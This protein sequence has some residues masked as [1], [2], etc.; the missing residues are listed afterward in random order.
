MNRKEKATIKKSIFIL[1]CF[2][3]LTACSHP[4]NDNI[5]SAQSSSPPAVSTP[6]AES[7]P[8]P[9]SPPP[10]ETSPPG[11]PAA[12]TPN[13]AA[14]EI[15]TPNVSQREL[16]D[17]EALRFTAD[18]KAGW[19]LGN[20]FDSTG[21][22]V[23]KGLGETAWGNPKTTREM[24]QKIHE[25]GF[26]SIRIPV[27]WHDH[28]DADFNIDAAWMERVA[29]VAGYALD[30]NMYVILNIH[31]D[32]GVKYVYPDSEHY[33]NSSKYIKTVWKQIAEQ[34]KDKSEKLI[35]ESINEPRLIGTEH[36]WDMQNVPDLYKDAIETLNKLN[37]D[38]VDTVRA[39]GGNNTDRCLMVPGICASP[40]SALHSSFKL[41][42][43]TAAGRLIV[44][45]HAYTPWNFA[46]AEVGNQS[47]VETFDMTQNSSTV[48]INGFMDKLYD[49]FIKN[50]IPVVIGEYG[51]IEKNGNLRDRIE[52]HAFY[53]ASA[54]ARGM[55]C[56][57]WDNGKRDPRKDGYALFDR[58]NGVWYF[59]DIIAAMMKYS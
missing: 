57:V 13:E 6:S 53:I 47:C 8:P 28:A 48:E 50:S 19:N 14:I 30:E 3:L 45:V 1:S 33:E 35:F 26:R 20:T 44:S 16:P 12:E 43:D 39:T 23:S 18:M 58:R 15:H 2:Y 11:A 37:Q 46:M 25:A 42:Q 4:V 5:P 22:G 24:I 32:D 31:H 59:P 41:P 10:A 55:T 17:S 40:G 52:Y 21:S 27:S 9:A 51:A 54:R 56:F 36:E 49:K 7:A 38:F 29:E 34:F